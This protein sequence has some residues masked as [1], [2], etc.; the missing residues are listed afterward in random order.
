MCVCVCVCRKDVA[1]FLFQWPDEFALVIRAVPLCFV[2][3]DGALLRFCPLV[4][5]TKFV[6]C[7]GAVGKCA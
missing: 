7:V 2:F 5:F 4:P 1:Y 3:I 6:W